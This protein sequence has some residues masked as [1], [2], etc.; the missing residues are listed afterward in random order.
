MRIAY[1]ELGFVFFDGMNV[2]LFFRFPFVA[3]FWGCFGI[4]R[5]NDLCEVFDVERAF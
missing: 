1:G 4:N 5:G 3:R 2:F